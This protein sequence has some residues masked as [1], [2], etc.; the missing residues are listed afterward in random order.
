VNASTGIVYFM[1]SLL[2]ND[3]SAARYRGLGILLCMF[4]GLT[5]QALCCRLLRR[6]IFQVRF[7]PYAE[8]RTSVSVVRL[9]PKNRAVGKHVGLT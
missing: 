6:L 4:L 2:L 3:G 8:F 1:A 5:P 7:N 9:T